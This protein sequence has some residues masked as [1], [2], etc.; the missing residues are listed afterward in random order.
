MIVLVAGYDLIDAL[1]DLMFMMPVVAAVI[2]RSAVASWASLLPLALTS[3][4]YFGVVVLSATFRF[5]G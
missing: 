2:F 4:V 5:L 3:F 1:V